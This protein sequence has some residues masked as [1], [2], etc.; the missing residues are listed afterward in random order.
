MERSESLETMKSY[1]TYKAREPV[2]WRGDKLT[3]FSSVVSGVASLTKSMEDGRTQVVGLLL[4]S[5]FL[6]RPGRDTV[7][8]DVTAATDITLC[9]F[10]KKPF[11]KLLSELKLF[12]GMGNKWQ[13]NQRYALL[14]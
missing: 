8:H 11:E 3:R 6:G 2:L 13:L 7:A 1:H 9:C 5:D 14:V 10:Q 12:E 4:P